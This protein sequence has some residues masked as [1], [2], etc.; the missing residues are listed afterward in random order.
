MPQTHFRFPLDGR[1]TT[2]MEMRNSFLEPATVDIRRSMHSTNDHEDWM[3]NNL[4]RWWID[5]GGEG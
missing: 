2:S 4:D 1:S 5:L 3:A